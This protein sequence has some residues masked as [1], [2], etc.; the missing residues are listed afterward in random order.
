MAVVLS[1][2]ARYPN[3]PRLSTSATT[4][5]LAR[6]LNEISDY[7]VRLRAAGVALP[8]TVAQR[9]SLLGHVAVLDGNPHGTDHNATQ[10]IQGGSAAERYHLTLS[11][12]AEAAALDALSAGLVAK[13]GDAAY[14]PRALTGTAAEITVVNGDGGA[15]N[16]TVSLPAR[17]S[18][19]RKFGDTTDNLEIEADGTIKF[20]GAATVWVDIDFRIISRTAIAGQPTPAVLIGTLRAPQWA[21]NDYFDCQGEELIHKWKEASEVFWHIHVYQEVDATDSFLNFSVEYTWANV[22]QTGETVPATTTV[23]SGDLLVPGGSGLKFFIFPITSFVP[24]GGRIA[25]HVKP[26]LTRIASVGA[27][28][29]ND[30]F[31]EMLQLHVECDTAGSREMT[32][33]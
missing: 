24:V 31:C 6:A 33:K 2:P 10:S 30:P 3:L 16:P 28:P 13:T 32:T 5:E 23:S 8:L 20:N 29:T 19:P 26:K 1:D 12:R 17:I 7:F 9:A 18:G 27:A 15:G 22:S 4:A 21:V 25:A 14:A 11:E